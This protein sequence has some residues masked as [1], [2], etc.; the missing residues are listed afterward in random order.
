[1]T[2]GS[3]RSSFAAQYPESN[4]P[5]VGTAIEGQ[6]PDENDRGVT[7]LT[8]Q[9]AKA[10]DPVMAYI[11]TN[12]IDETIKLEKVQLADAVKIVFYSYLMTAVRNHKENNSIV[13]VYLEN[14]VTL[15]DYMMT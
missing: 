3:P 9:K 13:P 10:I 4:A 2:N 5:K 14:S 8:L 11:E 7:P 12:T 6:C 15:L 1:M